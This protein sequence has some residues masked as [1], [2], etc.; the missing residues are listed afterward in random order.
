MMLGAVHS[1]TIRGGPRPDVAHF[2]ALMARRI[3]HGK[4]R[5]AGEFA[6]H[7][8]QLIVPPERLRLTR[9]QIAWAEIVGPRLSAVAWP[10]ALRGTQLIVYVRDTQ[11]QHELVYMKDQ[12]LQRLGEAC[13]ACPVASLRFRVGEIPPPAPEAPPPP[14]PDIVE[15]SAEPA[16]DTIEALGRVDDEALRKLMAS[17]RMAL[18]GPLRR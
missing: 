18:S 3:D 16:P 10:G 8:V 9:L 2:K 5:P 15:L 11:W 12:L 7:A 1:D 14:P 4:R 13:T 6:K 17:A